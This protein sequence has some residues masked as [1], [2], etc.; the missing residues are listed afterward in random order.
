MI[1]EGFIQTKVDL[2]WIHSG[3]T[4]V[5]KY[6]HKGLREI[7]KTEASCDCL[8]INNEKSLSRIL[9]KY[10]PKKVPIHLREQNINHYKTQKTITVSYTT[11]DEPDHIKV[12]VL[13]LDAMVMD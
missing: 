2:G 9:I 6:P 1:T 7:I 13:V 10:K 12:V 5:A 11:N 8:N 3:K 4:Y